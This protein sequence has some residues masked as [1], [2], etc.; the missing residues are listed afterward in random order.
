MT[1]RIQQDRYTEQINNLLS[2]LPNLNRVREIAELSGP[3]RELT[4]LLRQLESLPR[5]QQDSDLRDQL[6]EQ[7][8]RLDDKCLRLNELK[9][10]REEIEN[11]F[12]QARE[13][14]DNGAPFFK[15]DDMYKSA[16]DY[17]QGRDNMYDWDAGDTNE[18]TV[19]LSLAERE[20]E[21]YS[22][23]HEKPTTRQQ[24]GEL[25]SQIMIFAEQA[26]KDP[27]YEVSY[28]EKP[29]DLAEEIRQRGEGYVDYRAKSA[30][31]PVGRALG[32]AK[33][34]L[35]RWWDEKTEDYLDAARHRLE[36]DHLPREAR[37]E[38]QRFE[39]LPGLNNPRIGLSVS[40]D[41][42][43]R[44]TRMRAEIDEAIRKLDA[45]ERELRNAERL[46]DGAQ[47][48]ALEA[49]NSLLLAEEHYAFAPGIEATRARVVKV[50]RAQIAPLPALIESHLRRESWAPARDGLTQLGLLL[51]LQPL[52]EMSDE[53]ANY[54][55][56]LKISQDIGPLA[57]GERLAAAAE[58]GVLERLY[59][60]YA[61]TYWPDW[62]TLAQRLAQLQT[63]GNFESLAEL[64][65]RVG[66]NTKVS[67]LQEMLDTLT[68]LEKKPPANA[69]PTDL[70]KVPAMLRRVRGW[71]GY[72]MARD[73]LAKA[74]KSGVDTATSLDDLYFDEVADL[75]VVERALEAAKEDQSAYE[76]T[77]AGR[78]ESLVRHFQRL[79][80]NDA[81]A[82]TVLTEARRITT[83]RQAVTAVVLADLLGQL[84]SVINKPN[85]RRTELL[86][87]HD[88]I[89]RRLIAIHRAELKKL[90]D[91]GRHPDFYGSLNEKDLEARV[92]QLNELQQA[93][94]YDAF[95]PEQ[96][97][98]IGEAELARNM[99]RAHRIERDAR[100]MGSAPWENVKNGWET[101]QTKAASD[102]EAQ[103]FALRRSRMAYKHI[104]FKEAGNLKDATDSESETNAA[105]IELLR[106]LT[107]DPFLRDD[108][109][110]WHEYGFALFDLAH[111]SIRP[112]RGFSVNSKNV[113]VAIERVNTARQAFEN[114]ERLK[115][116]QT[117]SGAI[118]V[119]KSNDLKLL[120]KAVEEYVRA[121]QAFN[122]YQETILKEK[123]LPGDYLRI[124]QK[125]NETAAQLTEPKEK[126]FNAKAYHDG[127]WHNA[128][129]YANT[130]L[131]A[132]LG[133]LDPADTLGRLNLLLI[134]AVLNPDNDGSI[135][136]VNNQ[137][138]TSLSALDTLVSDTIGDHSGVKFAG[139]YTDREKRTP[140]EPEH[141]A[142]QLEEARDTRQAL[143]DYRDTL[144]QINLPSFPISAEDLGE[145]ANSLNEW[146]SSLV[147]FNG[148]LTSAGGLITDGLKETRK[149]DM[150]ERILK[151]V[152]NEF[153][154]LEPVAPAFRD[155]GHPTYRWVEREY[156]ARKN[157]R[158]AQEEFHNTIRG[159]IDEE[160]RAVAAVISIRSGNMP[161]EDE[162]QLVRELPDT[163]R[164]LAR[165]LSNM[166]DAEP[167]DDTLL[168]QDLEYELPEDPEKSY[169]GAKA[170]RT[171]VLNKLRQY[172]DV[173]QWLAIWADK[174]G[175]LRQVVDW[176][177]MKQRIKA[178]RNRGPA[179]L[180]LNPALQQC[181]DVMN[182]SGD[183]KMYEGKWALKPA[184]E[185]LGETA[186]RQ[187][188]LGDSPDDDQILYVVIE[189]L[190][191]KRA[192]LQRQVAEYISDNEQF[193][194]N[195]VWR[196]DHFNA[197][198]TTFVA[199]KNRM[200]AT[201]KAP[202]KVW[203]SYPAYDEFQAAGQAFAQIFPDYDK[204]RQ[205]EAEVSIHTGLKF[206]FTDYEEDKYASS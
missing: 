132:R 183:T 144:A 60:D 98:L 205:G 87:T 3:T 148:R 138:A 199:A 187:A 78:P 198:F 110:V 11:R 160:S 100:T 18:L 59:T 50:A 172:D 125:H 191:E 90:L 147:S 27:N 36:H 130:T 141:L 103:E 91:G 75:Q 166:I 190:D 180:G 76:A 115:R 86:E 101:A 12:R 25:A 203:Q 20:R 7:I 150:V 182:G 171:V 56:L 73:E 123:A 4:Q 55:R 62:K 169:L 145:L 170:I 52:T 112:D 26:E 196:G 33:D 24:G 10:A 51:E 79:Q 34:L 80:H 47:P 46:L 116:G 179:D 136:Q 176:P 83:R 193:D 44:V 197:R 15:V 173:E 82:E 5:D 69:R 129:A 114:A 14:H 178:R 167:N 135:Q 134:L 168:Q 126:R 175:E 77:R 40:E 137:A 106:Q 63:L 151:G 74:P 117:I 9:D 127:L 68:E 54:H 70:A 84:Q 200:L 94:G 164:Q 102:K 162:R 92:R 93:G 121:F 45:A 140:S 99:A 19:L 39:Q 64:V 8:G 107:E 43:N 38:L 22:D 139:R 67:D 109:E 32:I 104:Q 188:A 157:R 16:I 201:K 53:R 186:M 65:A 128:K 192:E 131:Q 181:R 48:D 158:K 88:E 165:S 159:L 185:A 174:T 206:H 124:V 113:A 49:L 6:S 155:A 122:I 37:G 1:E 163:L 95:D 156:K 202:W 42:R 184:H 195:M 204:F 2:G 17:I 71:L 13:L 96:D 66:T 153:V 61:D 31:M 41:S 57:T 105:G 142:R 21:R 108:W 133:V 35:F 154:Q 30:R 85:S 149:F 118:E 28:F 152:E 29:E 120:T 161:T 143:S 119:R 111:K 89:R 97:K 189:P 72:A 177:G 194:R 81:T 146:I 58:R 23:D